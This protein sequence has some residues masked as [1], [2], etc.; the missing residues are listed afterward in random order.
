MD[1]H[2]SIAEVVNGGEPGNGKT[3]FDDF[4]DNDRAKVDG[5][6]LAEETQGDAEGLFV[7]A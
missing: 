7:E 4:A 5:Q 3:F 1:R 6:V 2:G